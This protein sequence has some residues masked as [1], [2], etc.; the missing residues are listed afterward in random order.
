MKEFRIPFSQRAHHYTES[1]LT[2]AVTVMRDAV[3]LTQGKHLQAFESRFRDYAGIDHAFAVSNATA[4]LELAAQL[5]QFKT[6][7]EVVIPSHTF[8]S[9]A[10][11]FAKAGARI[12]WADIDPATRV[13]SVETIAPCI[14]DRTRALVVPH[15]YGYGADMPGIMALAR[16]HE[17]IVV[18]D[19]AQALGVMITTEWR[20]PSVILGCIP[21]TRTRTSL[22]LERVG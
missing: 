12:I 10:Y 20:A 19:V 13:V 7:D 18:E 11:P 2:A 17:L 22:P 9:S 5:C 14:S 21:S 3:P 8:T 15:L 1:E 4:G 16:A 6:G